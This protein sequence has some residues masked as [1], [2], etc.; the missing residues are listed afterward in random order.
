MS[1]A[2]QLKELDKELREIQS[3]LVI[4]SGNLRSLIDIHRGIVAELE[5]Q[6]SQETSQQT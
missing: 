5:A 1:I 3:T 4:A 2:E 6:N